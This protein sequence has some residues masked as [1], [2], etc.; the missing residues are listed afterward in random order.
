MRIVFFYCRDIFVV[1]KVEEE[2][3][4]VLRSTIERPLSLFGGWTHL[5]ITLPRD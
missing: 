3:A 5:L 1:V 2:K 4:I